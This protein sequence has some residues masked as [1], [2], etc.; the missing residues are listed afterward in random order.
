MRGFAGRIKICWAIAFLQ[1]K[2]RIRGIDA[3][4]LPTADGQA[5]KA[6]LA[7]FLKGAPT[8]VLNLPTVDLFRVLHRLRINEIVSKL[9]ES[10]TPPKKCA[11]DYWLPAAVGS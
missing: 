7:D 4:E 2:V 8:V 5:A 3:P 10:H 6:F 1:A 9:N 11:R